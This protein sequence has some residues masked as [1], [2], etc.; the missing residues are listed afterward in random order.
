MKPL[1]R[2]WSTV[3][4]WLPSGVDRRVVVVAWAS[5][6]C[7][8]VLVGTGGLVRLTGSGLGCPTWPQCGDGS[9]V[10]TPAMGYHGVIEFGNRML[11]FVLVIVV[12][13]AFLSILRFRKV[14]RD[15]FW[16]TFIQGMSIPFQAV[17]G[18]ISVLAKLNPYV[19]GSHFI[20]SMILVRIATTLVY[21]VTHGPRGT[22][23]ATPAW[24]ANVARVTAVF[25]AITVVLGIL[26]TGAGP[27]AGDAHTHRNGLDPRVIEVVH[28]VPAFAVFGLTILL[29]IATYRLGLPRRLVT[30]LLAVEVA[31]IA[32][33]LIQANTGLP[34]LLVGAHLVLAALLVSAMTAVGHTLQSDVDLTA[35]PADAAAAA[36]VR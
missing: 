10:T 34:S 23:A 27:H 24:F 5:L 13:A 21:R 36:A 6:V 18:G 26:T 16:L 9:F 19:V 29:V 32:V 8:I 35:A 7:Q 2:L 17:L 31:Q 4:S 11:T 15:L 30:M 33:G 1:G 20:V 14:R 12:I 28:A 22:S 25:V 3:W